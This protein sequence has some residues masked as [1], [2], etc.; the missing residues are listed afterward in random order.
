M[1][2]QLIYQGVYILD[3]KQELRNKLII[4]GFLSLIGIVLFNV[5]LQSIK[6]VTMALI[7][8]QSTFVISYFFTLKIERQ[9]SQYI[10]SMSLA[11]LSL[12][13]MFIHVTDSHSQ[14]VMN[15]EQLQAFAMLATS[16]LVLCVIS[17]LNK[18]L[19]TMNEKLV[20]FY[21]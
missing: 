11:L 20:T 9:Q 10:V 5:G 17:I 7:I 14:Q 21:S 12:I 18:D 19:F 4:R 3:I 16:G 6:S 8:Q 2:I 13:M 15:M 1:F